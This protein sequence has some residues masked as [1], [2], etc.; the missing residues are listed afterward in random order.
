MDEIP[1]DELVRLIKRVQLHSFQHWSIV[2]YPR[3]GRAEFE[4]EVCELNRL[5][6]VSAED[7]AARLL[8]AE[9]HHLWNEMLDRD[10]WPWP[11]TT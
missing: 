4:A 6:P 9:Y 7:G 2:N 3:D 1:D 10:I 5:S 11:S 8:D